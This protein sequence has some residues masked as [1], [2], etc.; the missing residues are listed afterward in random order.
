MTTS[1]ALQVEHKSAKTPLSEQGDVKEEGS[2][3]WVRDRRLNVRLPLGGV[4]SVEPLRRL[5]KRRN[6]N[7][8]CQ[9]LGTL[10]GGERLD[11]GAELIAQ[12]D[13]VVG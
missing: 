2:V 13:A 9:L 6:L 8:L 1:K 10:G 11:D 12:K 5:V 7:S 3:L 4:C